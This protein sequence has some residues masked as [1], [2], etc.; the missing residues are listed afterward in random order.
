MKRPVFK[1]IFKKEL[2]LYFFGTGFFLVSLIFSI[3]LFVLFRFTYPVD[4]LSIEVA[5][6]SL[7]AVHLISS[8][9]TLLASQEWEWER[10]ALR[11]IKISG[12]EGHVVFLGK[13]ISSWFCLVLLLMFEIVAWIIFFAYSHL[14][15]L[16]PAQGFFSA[17]VGMFMA[18]LFASGVIASAGISFLG[19]L[20]SILALHSRF[21]HVLLFIV[22]F[23]LSLPAI[24]AGSSYSRFAYQAAEWTSASGMI[25]LQMAY[26]F[27]FLSAGVLLY[28]FLWEE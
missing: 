4:S 28:E 6:S 27:V 1:S 15:S 3:G 8:L 22:F 17:K 24:I 25:S 23:P 20:A 19:Q 11:A 16:D 12:V 5:I 14:T 21:R 18:K 2:T 9:F 13:A 10:N 26:A 7:W